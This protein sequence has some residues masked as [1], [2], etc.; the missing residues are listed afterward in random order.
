MK[1]KEKAD[2]IAKNLTVNASAEAI[3]VPNIAFITKMKN[4][5]NSPPR[6]ERNHRSA[7]RAKSTPGI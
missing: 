1:K 5:R 2:M 4:P 3:G 6:M 7:L